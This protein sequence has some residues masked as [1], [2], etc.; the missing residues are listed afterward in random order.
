MKKYVSPIMEI[1]EVEEVIITTSA[2]L[3]W[4]DTEN[5]DDSASMAQLDK[6]ELAPVDTGSSG[7]E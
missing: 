5:L 7:G 3:N 4:F 6:A 1:Y 2:L